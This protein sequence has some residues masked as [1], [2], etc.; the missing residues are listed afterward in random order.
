MTRQFKRFSFAFLR[1]L[2]QIMLQE[3]AATGLLFLIAIAFG[4]P[5]LLLGTAIGAITGTLVAKILKIDDVKINQGLF[6]YNAALVGM[7]IF[8]FYDINIASILLILFCSILSSYL[9]N[10]LFKLGLKIPAYTA[11]FV[12]ST[13]LMLLLAP[14]LGLT[15]LIHNPVPIQDDSLLNYVDAVGQV[16]FQESSLVS[17]LFIIALAFHS[18]R[19]SIWAML[20][21]VFAAVFAITF[22]FPNELINLGLFGYNAVLVAIVLSAKFGLNPIPTLLG[23]VISVIFTRG[24]QLIE[25]P[26]LTAPFVLTCWLINGGVFMW[27]QK[28][29]KSV[30]K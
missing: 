4:S 30:A 2:S 12:I 7:A 25:I 22:G 18:F 27:N 9:L 23:I 20:A 28:S 5:S 19:A 1:G 8:F 10:S 26:A 6:G 17:F 13:W 16:M 29:I 24:F 3:N 14:Y 11:P 15:L 21:S